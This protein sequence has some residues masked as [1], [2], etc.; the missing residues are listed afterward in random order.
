M[1]IRER[2]GYIIEYYGFMILALLLMLLVGGSLLSGLFGEEEASGFSVAA[3]NQSY[4]EDTRRLWEDALGKAYGETPVE[5]DSTYQ[6]DPE[7]FADDTEQGYLMKLSANL[8]AGEIDL[9]I[10]DETAFR[11]FS[12]LDAL[13]DIH[14]LVQE[15][16]PEG[17]FGEAGESPL[18]PEGEIGLEETFGLIVPDYLRGES[19]GNSYLVIPRSSEYVEGYAE[20]IRI[21]YGP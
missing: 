16:M 3:V 11:H 2:I 10:L 4:S 13:R 17:G 20:L 8:F 9:M 19:A 14:P 15:T 1:S 6:V 12:E 5:F 7:G 21:L 18:L